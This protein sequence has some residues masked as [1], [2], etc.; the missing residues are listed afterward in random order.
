VLF[1]VIVISEVAF[2]FI[3][4]KTVMLVLGLGL[5]TKIFGLGLE[6]QVLGLG[7]APSGPGLGLDVIL[8]LLTH[9]QSHICILCHKNDNC[10]LLKCCHPIPF[11]MQLVS[12]STST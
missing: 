8:A 5:K 9:E 11:H 6:S 10:M 2:I 1:E 3:K 7:L 12:R 4:Q